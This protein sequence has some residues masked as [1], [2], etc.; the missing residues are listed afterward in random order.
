MMAGSRSKILDPAMNKG[1]DKII[2]GGTTAIEA[3]SQEAAGQLIDG[4]VPLLP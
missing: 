4:L 2:N 1:T 3:G